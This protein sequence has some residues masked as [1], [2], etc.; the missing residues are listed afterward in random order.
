MEG[1]KV[2]FGMD[3]NWLQGRMSGVVEQNGPHKAWRIVR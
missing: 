3:Q 1:K 2:K